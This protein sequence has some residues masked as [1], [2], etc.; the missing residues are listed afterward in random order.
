MSDRGQLVLRKTQPH[1]NGI[2]PAIHYHPPTTTAPTGGP[3]IVPGGPA[4]GANPVPG[5]VAGLVAGP[6]VVPSGPAVGANPVPGPVAG[7]VAGPVYDP[8]TNGVRL[9]QLRLVPEPP[10]YKEPGALWTCP[11]C[12][13]TIY[14]NKYRRHL[15]THIRV[16]TY[17]GCNQTFFDQTN[18]N[19]VF[20][21]VYRD[22]FEGRKEKDG[23]SWPDCEHSGGFSRYDRAYEHL[24]WDHILREN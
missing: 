3:V 21:H 16:C 24:G 22:H 18:A 13:R 7:L 12:D 14:M 2:N 8:R 5:P 9:D 20:R 17:P 1:G 4:V 10:Y 15:T 19:P 23:C 11:F 6:V